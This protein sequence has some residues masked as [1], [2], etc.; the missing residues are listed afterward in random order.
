NE[1]KRLNLLTKRFGNVRNE[2]GCFYISKCEQ[3]VKNIDQESSKEVKELFRKSFES[4]NSGIKAFESIKD[5]SNIALL[6]NNLGR[7]MRLYAQFY[8]PIVNEV[9]GEF[10]PQERQY[11]NKA[12]DYYLKGLKLVENRGDLYKTLSWELSGAYYTYATI[13]QDYAP[14]SKH[15]QED[16]EKEVIDYMT[17]SLKYLEIETTS[18]SGRNS[19]AIYRAATI[20]HRLA[21]LFHN[22]LRNPDSKTKRKHLRSLAS[23]HYQ[24]ALKLFSVQ[25]NPLEYLRVQLEEVALADYELQNATENSSRLKYAQQGLK[26][27]FQCQK[28]IEIIEQRHLSTDS[29]DYTETFS[30]EAHR[31]LAILNGRIQ[32]FLKEIAKIT[33]TTKKKLNENENSIIFEDYKEMYS[34]A[35]RLNEQLDTFPHDLIQAFIRMKKIYDKHSITVHD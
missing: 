15:P 30:Q 19:L 5:I 18:S 17:K 11:Y 12:F 7:L 28:C 31:L 3:A 29:D 33:K 22:S 16:I 8:A 6:Y 10:S 26:E 1:R 24:K 2:M 21:S 23:F 34:I 20:H 4:F 35:L 13:L 27:G 14:L 32:S 25:E 9:R